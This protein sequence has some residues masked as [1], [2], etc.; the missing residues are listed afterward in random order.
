MRNKGGASGIVEIAG[1][2]MSHWIPWHF[3]HCYNNE[4]NRAGILRATEIVPEGGI[5][6][7]ADGIAL[8]A[9][10]PEDLKRR[11][12]GKDILY[13]LNLVYALNRFGMPED[14]VEIAEK[15]GARAIM[16]EALKSPRAIHPAVWT[17]ATGEKVLHISPWMA[18]GIVGA[19]NPEGD[20]L[21]AEVCKTANRLADEISYHHA[22]K[23]TD[24]VIWDN[25]RMVHS[26]SGNAP[27]YGRT[28][29]RTTIKGDYGLGRF[30]DGRTGDKVLEMT[31]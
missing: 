9:A 7:F 28:M 25:W 6:G 23:P 14:L 10:F 30:E 17:R 18:D 19:E 26:V 20:A 16:E 15:P 8:Y 5:T 1:K 24:M 13:T 27:E 29:Q 11:I 21:L 22:W 2:R 3:D 12:E 31:V 4:L